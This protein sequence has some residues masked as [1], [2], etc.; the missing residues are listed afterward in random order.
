MLGFWPPLDA[1]GPLAPTLRTPALF[2]VVLPPSATAPPPVN[3]EPAVTV[4]EGLASI[5]LV[6]PALAMLTVPELV[7]GPPASPAP[8]AT[9]VT[10][11]P[12][13]PGNTWPGAK[14]M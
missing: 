13:V 12:P 9:L 4:N 3:P 6:T 2:S 7:M 11:P 1:S 8:V 10:D 5:P 14:L